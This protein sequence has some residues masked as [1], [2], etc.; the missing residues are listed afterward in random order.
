MVELSSGVKDISQFFLQVYDFFASDVIG[1][2]FLLIT[3]SQVEKIWGKNAIAKK[4][5][6]TQKSFQLFYN[7]V[8]YVTSHLL[9]QVPTKIVKYDNNM[10]TKRYQPKLL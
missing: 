6:I 2:N 4:V 3:A 9:W 7:A 10:I 8:G 1:Q 5:K